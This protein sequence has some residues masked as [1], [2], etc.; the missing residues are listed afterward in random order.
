MER[1]EYLLKAI[2]TLILLSLFTSAIAYSQ[3]D[4]Y[5]QKIY[6][7]YIN[8]NM[9]GWQEV[10]KEVEAGTKSN[11]VLKRELVNYYYGLIGYLISVKDNKNATLYTKKGEDIIE[12]YL[13][14]YPQSATWLAYKAA[15]KGFRIG[16]SNFKAIT[17]GIQSMNLAK[18]AYSIDPSNVQALTERGNVLYYSPSMV[19]GDKKEG[20]SYYEKAIEQIEKAGDTRDNWHY[21]SLLTAVARAYESAGNRSKA[22]TLYEKILVIEPGYKWVRDELYP[23]FLQSRPV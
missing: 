15:F 11:S 23:S 12:E 22:K 13:D 1:K 3:G 14:R 18:K 21:L 19:G 7:C 4:N 10:V 6:N 2:F 8:G 17:L 9:R 20:I 5:R 16:I